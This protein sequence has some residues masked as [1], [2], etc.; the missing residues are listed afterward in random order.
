MT[1]STEPFGCRGA[2]PGIE[3]ATAPQHDTIGACISTDQQFNL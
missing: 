3:K 1:A 2:F